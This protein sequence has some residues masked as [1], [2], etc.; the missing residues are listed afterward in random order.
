M[1]EVRTKRKVKRVGRERID[2]VRALSFRRG[3]WSTRDAV[4]AYSGTFERK[5]RRQ[6]L[7]LDDD[8]RERLTDRIARQV[9]A[10]EAARGRTVEA[11]VTLV[12]ERSTARV[13]KSKRKGPSVKWK[14]RHRFEVRLTGD[15]EAT[16]RGTLRRSGVLREP[17]PRTLSEHAAPLPY[18][19][20][21]GLWDRDDLY[22][23]RPDVEP[24]DLWPDEVL[25]PG[26]HGVRIVVL[27][28]G[29]YRNRSN[30]RL[31]PGTLYIEDSGTAEQPLLITYAPEVGADLTEV[32]HAAERG[33]DEEAR[34]NSIRIFA[35]RHQ[36]FHGLTFRDG[37]ASSLL[38]TASDNV[39]DGCLWHE[40]TFQPLRIRFNSLRNSVQHCVMRRFDR[41]SW[42]NGDTVAIQLSDEVLTDN[43]I[44]G[45]VILNYTDSYQHTDRD[46]DAYGL[47]AGTLVADN[48]MGFTP[49]AYLTDPSGEVMCGE[50]TIDLKMGG[51]EEAP[52]LVTDN[53]FF[54]VRAAQAGCA[55]SGSGGYAVTLHR[56]GTW[57]RFERNRFID[58][59]SGIFLNSVFQDT[60]PAQGR[61]DPNWTFV[62]NTFSGIRSRSTS[63][64]TRTGRVLSGLSP[65][66]FTGNTVLDSDRLLESEP[67]AGVG[68]LVLQDND[69]VGPLDLAPR[70][71]A[72]LTADGNRVTPDAATGETT[73]LVPWSDLVL[74]YRVRR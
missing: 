55:A 65:A 53:V 15:V 45:N 35:Q 40:T 17:P 67:F 50:N 22:V 31:G 59:D 7:S 64:P 36:V 6:V 2:A 12:R 43:H 26:D 62:G 52:A 28:P 18:V 72:G 69:L 16:R 25:F 9:E 38:H 66:T 1:G 49:E 34:L 70:D 24:L 51:T 58:L 20:D 19:D 32:A 42:G 13:R 27:L 8:S 60:E 21:P 23:M 41:E 74:S 47:G 29:D 68:E 61:I 14:V 30:G 54:G 3:R 33:P 48:V 71:A 4:Q 5:G 39:L 11:N 56:R 37:P 10:D 44:V 63:F 46:G 57:V 73:F